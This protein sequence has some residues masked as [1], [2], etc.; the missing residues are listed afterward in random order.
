MENILNALKKMYKKIKGLTVGN[1]SFRYSVLYGIVSSGLIF[2]KLIVSFFMFDSTK[3][4]NSILYFV[5]AV[6]MG[7]MLIALIIIQYRE[8]SENNSL[9]KVVMQIFPFY[10]LIVGAITAFLYVDFYDTVFSFFVITVFL[11]WMQLYQIWK[12]ILLFGFG[13][14]LFNSIGLIINGNQYLSQRYLVFSIMA[15]LVSFLT[16]S[17]LNQIFFNNVA[18]VEELDSEMKKANAA[19]K[20]AESSNRELLKSKT[21]TKSMFETVSEVMKNEKFE[22]V[23]QLVLEKA[24]SLIP[25]GQ[26]GSILILDDEKMKFVAAKGYN[27]NNLKK[28]ELLPEDLYQATLEDKYQP[29]IIKNLETFDQAHLGEKKTQKFKDNV[30]IAKSCLTCSF[31]HEGIFFGSINID[32]FDEE[33]IFDDN[34][35]YL[36]KQLAQ[37]LELIISVHKLYEQA[38]RPTKYDELT[39]AR[40]RTYCI[41]LLKNM[42]KSHP[43]DTISICTF[44]VNNLKTINDMYGHDVGDK[45]LAF[46]AN[47]IRNAE[48]QENIFGRIGGDEFLLVFQNLNFEQ[49]NEQIEIIREYMNNRPFKFET[50]KKNITFSAGVAVYS[51]DDANLDNLI[52]LSDKRMY[53]DKQ[54]QK[55]L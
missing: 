29:T 50:L 21:I 47:C 51:I 7:L 48:I 17:I 52:K 18:A 28:I 42:I 2:G 6:L 38:I 43:K 15:I 25:E 12:R 4:S 9:A 44:D 22:D 8:N 5:C 14:V 41:R 27:L 16:S 26:A 55:Q 32:N 1:N 10:I 46:F 34:D 3:I 36:I 33:D 11:S 40:T 53:E 35:K 39:Q 31:Q 49:A 30:V 23:L 54:A 37:E 45:Y 13:L 20:L 24:V 19:Y